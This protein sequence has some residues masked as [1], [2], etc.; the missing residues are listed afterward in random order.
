MEV[1]AV[2]DKYTRDAKFEK[3]Q[4]ITELK[5]RDAQNIAAENN[6]DY[7]STF[8][9]VSAAKM[10]YYQ[11]LGAYSPEFSFGFS[12]G[13]QV[14]KNTNLKNPPMDTAPQNNSFFTKSTLRGTYL[15]FDGLA[16]ELQMLAANTDIARTEAAKQ[17]VYRLLMRSVSYAYYDVMLACE[18][19]RIT[20][21]EVEYFKVNAGIGDIRFSAGKLMKAVNLNLKILRNNA[22]AK[23]VDIRAR[24]KVAMFALSCLMGYPDGKLPDH[25][26]FPHMNRTPDVILKGVETYLDEA[27]SNRPDLKALSE[28]IKMVNYQRLSK[29]SPYLPTVTFFTELGYDTNLV[30]FQRYM[31]EHSGWN[32]AGVGYGV[33]VGWSFFEGFRRYNA[34]RQFNHLKRMAE[35]ELD[36]TAL[37]A[38]NEVRTAMELFRAALDNVKFYGEQ[39]EWVYEQRKLVNEGFWEGKVNVMRFREAE[40][41]LVGAETNLASSLIE[42]YKTHAQ[43]I[44]AVN[45]EPNSDYPAAGKETLR[46]IFDRLSAQHPYGA[47]VKP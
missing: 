34:Y 39:L 43:L 40:F 41:E 19:E 16:R 3:L 2:L 13:Q 33:N 31:R 42:T 29:L 22:Q 46:E 14:D 47:N 36:N 7:A 20:E 32:R 35:L 23:L 1:R 27:V 21:K 25:I 9:A 11:S 4:G 26:V 17:N 10:V 5:L 15:I 8:Q 30:G 18:L 37:M 28:Y 44:A 6:P 45:G 24:K 38:I 12:V